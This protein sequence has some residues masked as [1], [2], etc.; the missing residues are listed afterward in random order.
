MSSRGLVVLF[1]FLKDKPILFNW[2]ATRNWCRFCFNISSFI[3]RNGVSRN[4]I[5]WNGWL[6]WQ[7]K[8]LD[9]FSLVSSNWGWLELLDLLNIQVSDQVVSLWGHREQSSRRQGTL[10]VS[11]RKWKDWGSSTGLWIIF[12][13]Q[14]ESNTNMLLK[15]TMHISIGS[16]WKGKGLKAVHRSHMVSLLLLPQHIVHNIPLCWTQRN[17]LTIIKDNKRFHLAR[18]KVHHSVASISFVKGNQIVDR[19]IEYIQLI[20]WTLSL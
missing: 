13:F 9:A 1:F 5:R 18:I 2:C 17:N 11:T 10:C 14:E 20:A 8:C 16:V 3:G 12:W 7:F 19:K 4:F 15:S 6:G